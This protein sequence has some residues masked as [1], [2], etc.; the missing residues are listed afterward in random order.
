MPDIPSLGIDLIDIVDP[1]M[2]NVEEQAYPRPLDLAQALALNLGRL[3]QASQY[4]PNGPPGV[5]QDNA[6][7]TEVFV[8]SQPFISP[9]L[10]LGV[11]TPDTPT[12]DVADQNIV[13]QPVVDYIVTESGSFNTNPAVPTT[14]R[15]TIASV[16]SFA[17]S[18]AVSTTTFYVI[19]FT[20]GTNLMDFGVDLVGT[21]ALFPDSAPA[22]NPQDVP[23]GLV[24]KFSLN[25]LVVDGT[26]LSPAPVAG[27][28]VDL[29]VSRHGDEAVFELYANDVNVVIDA[30]QSSSAAVTVV[31]DSHQM[32]DVFIEDEPPIAFIGA[33]TRIP[34]LL[35]VGLRETAFFPSDRPVTTLGLPINVNVG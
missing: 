31:G 24:T 18:G 23:A 25:Q 10:S 20:A 17:V 5:H 34:L 15:R 26:D 4:W 22:L 35:Y 21:E 13:H 14:V 2:V 16:T 7:P 8:E 19:T 11:A 9:S 33:G 27:D 32:V 28:V 6:T 3:I 12:T 29:D 30:V 1:G